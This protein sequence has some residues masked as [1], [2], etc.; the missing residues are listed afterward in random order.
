VTEK[1]VL[2]RTINFIKLEM[3]G[4]ESCEMVGVAIPAGDTAELPA[5]LNAC[6]VAKIL[7]PGARKNGLACRSDS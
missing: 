5:A 7:A 1:S 4:S 3:Q 6:T 2:P